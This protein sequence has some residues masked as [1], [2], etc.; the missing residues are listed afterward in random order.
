MK[1]VFYIGLVFGFINIL[2]AQNVVLKTDKELGLQYHNIPC[3]EILDGH[4]FVKDSSI[5]TCA[6]KILKEY[7]IEANLENAYKEF[8][9]N[10][11]DKKA[12]RKAYL[13]RIYNM[14]TIILNYIMI[15]SIL[16][17][18]LSILNLWS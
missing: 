2:N 5:S 9:A 13:H 14:N 18:N 3:K 6:D 12:L 15:Q 7:V 10:H 17:M 16:S 11:P 1:L 8:I 4:S